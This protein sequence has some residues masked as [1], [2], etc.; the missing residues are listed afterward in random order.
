MAGLNTYD[1][2]TPRERKGGKCKFG[3]Y[4]FSHILWSLLLVGWGRGD[5]TI[6]L[7]CEPFNTLDA[8]PETLLCGPEP[9]MRRA[10]VLDLLGEP[11]L[12]GGELCGWKCGYVHCLIALVN[13]W[14]KG[15]RGEQTD[16]LRVEVRR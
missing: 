8:F 14:I 13:A 2:F 3:R 12:E 11:S 9:G 4:L 1:I 15:R 6:F 10:E 5:L 7:R 16:L